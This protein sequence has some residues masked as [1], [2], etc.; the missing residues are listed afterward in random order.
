MTCAEDLDRVLRSLIGD[1]MKPIYTHSSDGLVGKLQ[2]CCRCPQGVRV[3]D[4][5]AELYQDNDDDDGSEVPDPEEAEKEVQELVY[6]DLFFWA[7][8]TNRVEMAKVIMSHM[9]TRI[10]AA[11]IASKIMK[12]YQ[13]DAHDNESKDMFMGQAKQFEEYANDALKCCYNCYEDSA[14]E[15]VIRQ[16]NL[17]GGVSCLQVAVDAD[18]KSFVGQPC[19]DQL[20]NNIWYDKIEPNQSSSQYLQILLSI[21][22][23]G[24][25]AP[26]LVSFRKQQRTSKNL[27]YNQKGN[28]ELTVNETAED[29]EARKRLVIPT[30]KK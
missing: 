29:V 30:R 8:L 11:L 3:A 22:T 15:I 13:N 7:I 19:C 4:S 27:R 5:R 1:Y 2:T 9:Q 24:L 18:D 25:L 14:C 17:F 12:S 20:L 16:I 21:C 23:F 6:R 28:N 26:A 10:C